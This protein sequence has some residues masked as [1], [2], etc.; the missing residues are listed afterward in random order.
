MV[1][2]KLKTI[3]KTFLKVLNKIL[4]IIGFEVNIQRYEK[5]QEQEIEPFDD[6]LRLQKNFSKYKKVKLH[7]GC[8]PRVLKGSHL[9]KVAIVT[10]EIKRSP[11]LPAN[12]QNPPLANPFGGNYL[13]F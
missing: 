12:S 1:K 4:S 5:Q 13:K 8:G 2:S 3:S 11:T 9:A 7:I 10:S 6:V